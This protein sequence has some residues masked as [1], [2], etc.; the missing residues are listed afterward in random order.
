MVAGSESAQ[1][2]ALSHPSKA[3]RNAEASRE[4]DCPGH[5]GQTWGQ[6]D[7]LRWF[8]SSRAWTLVLHCQSIFLGVE[9]EE[10]RSTLKPVDAFFS[11]G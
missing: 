5:G 3:G 1:G 4:R 6:N 10:P 8:C 7:S 9:R 11:R 2:F